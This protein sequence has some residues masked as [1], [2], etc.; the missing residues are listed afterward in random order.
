MRVIPQQFE[1]ASIDSVRPHPRNPRSGNL[2]TIRESIDVNGWYGAVIV[3][4][5][6]GYI[7]AGNHRYRA[8]L[9]KGATEIPVFRLSVDDEQALRILLADNRTS[10][11]AIYDDEQLASLLS[12]L[13]AQPLG[14]DGTGFNETAMDELLAELEGNDEAHPASDETED[15]SERFEIIVTCSSD[16]EQRMLLDRLNVEGYSCRALVS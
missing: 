14:L 11:I 7:L 10:D 16:E 15:I 4:E 5:S 8:A 3:Q 13:S 12:E 9:Q 6:T 2:A 1:I